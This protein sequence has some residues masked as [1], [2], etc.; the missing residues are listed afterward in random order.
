MSEQVMSEQV[1][2]E[3]VNLHKLKYENLMSTNYHKAQFGNHE[4]T[5]D[6]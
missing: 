2:S 5:M 6:R 4:L 3:H 1:M